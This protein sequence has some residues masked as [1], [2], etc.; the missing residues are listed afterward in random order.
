[1][2]S[3]HQSQSLWLKGCQKNNVLAYK[4][5]KLVGVLATN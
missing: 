5:E 4:K 1:M 2:L 3:V